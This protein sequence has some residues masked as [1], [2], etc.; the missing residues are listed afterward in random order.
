MTSPIL[1]GPGTTYRAQ[2]G[3]VLRA[4]NWRAEAL[5]RM[6]ENVLEVGENPDELIV[7]AS[8]GKAARNWPA[9]RAIA[10]ALLDLEEHQTLVLQSG[11]PV[12][13]LETGEQAPLVLSA[14][15]NTVG[16]WA[17]P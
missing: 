2:R 6:F 17:T 10:T 7:Y 11:V 4:R 13:V 5:L 12:G 1:A 8:L 14:V 9:A 3:T 15:N 16:R